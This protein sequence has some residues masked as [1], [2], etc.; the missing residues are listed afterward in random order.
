MFI[1]AIQQS[2]SVIHK[3]TYLLFHFLFHYGLSQELHRSLCYGVRLNCLFILYIIVAS[4][5]HKLP[6]H[7]SLT[8]HPSGQPQICSVCLWLCFCFTDKFICIIFWIPHI[9]DIIWYLSFSD[10]PLSLWQSLGPLCCCRWYYFVL[11]YGEITLFE[12]SQCV[13]VW[14]LHFD[15]YSGFWLSLALGTSYILS[16]ICN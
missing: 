5:N 9:S 4:T 6:I 15:S 11:F 16:V 3:Y 12:C 7:P 14:S 1:S 10:L 8:L 2:D 13:C